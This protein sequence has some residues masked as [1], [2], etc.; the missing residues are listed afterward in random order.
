MTAARPVRA[1]AEAAI[2]AVD[3]LEAEEE[4]GDTDLAD[5]SDNDSLFGGSSA[6]CSVDEEEQEDSPAPAAAGQ[7]V[8]ASAVTSMSVA[9]RIQA[10]RL[11]DFRG[12]VF[13]LGQDAERPPGWLRHPQCCFGVA[14]TSGQ[15]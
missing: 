8:D 6:G 3:V 2:A 9:S 15:M 13:Y 4:A 12:H 11:N 5:E 14:D 7:D 1:A 10:H